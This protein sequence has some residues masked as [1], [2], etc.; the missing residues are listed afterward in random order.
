[1]S[2]PEENPPETKEVP[3]EYKMAIETWKQKHSLSSED[4]AFWLLELFELH[5]ARW[6]EIIQPDVRLDLDDRELLS[7]LMK[8]IQTLHPRVSELAIEVHQLKGGTVWIPPAR[9]AIV[10]GIAS[11]LGAGLLIGR[12][13]L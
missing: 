9:L 5:R 6:E 10:L 1:M 7:E 4:P 3:D 12:F 11:A 13:L 2:T 8:Q